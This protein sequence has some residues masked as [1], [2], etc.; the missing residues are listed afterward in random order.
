MQLDVLAC[1]LRSCRPA[2]FRPSPHGNQSTY[3]P[4]DRAADRTIE[5]HNPVSRLRKYLI[6][7]SSWP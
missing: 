7:K 1:C 5:N 4:T 6:H 3:Q 2:G